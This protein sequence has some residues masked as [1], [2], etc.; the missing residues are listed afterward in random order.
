MILLYKYVCRP[1]HE[2]AGQVLV[3]THTTRQNKKGADK[4]IQI[5]TFQR[6]EIYLQPALRPGCG[7]LKL[8]HIIPRGLK[9]N[10]PG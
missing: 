3:P 2:C 8:L 7:F 5:M 9:Y 1:H 4:I 6:S 10:S